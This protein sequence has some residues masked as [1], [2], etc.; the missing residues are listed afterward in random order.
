MYYNS[1]TIRN[2]NIIQNLES[3]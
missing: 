2:Q 1:G 3:I